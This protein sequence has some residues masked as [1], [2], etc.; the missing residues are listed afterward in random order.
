MTRIVSL[1]ISV[2]SAVAPPVGLVSSALECSTGKACSMSTG[3]HSKDLISGRAEYLDYF[4]HRRCIDPIF[5]IHEKATAGFDG[6]AGFVHLRHDVIVHARFLYMSSPRSFHRL[7]YHVREDASAS[8]AQSMT[9]SS[10]SRVARVQ[11]SETR[12]HSGMMPSAFDPSTAFKP[13][14]NSAN[15]SSLNCPAPTSVQTCT[16]SSSPAV[17]LTPLSASNVSVATADVRLLPSTNPWFCQTDCVDQVRPWRAACNT[18]DSMAFSPP[19]CT[20][21]QQKTRR[22]R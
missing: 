6:G 13:V 20:P 12:E 2:S 9:T 17:S 15:S 1:G 16:I 8:A 18:T 21:A 19:P 22:T 10:I 7:L 4:R 5:C 11:R 3:V 14:T